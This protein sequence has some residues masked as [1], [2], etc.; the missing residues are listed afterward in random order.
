MPSLEER[1]ALPGSWEEAGW[2]GQAEDCWLTSFLDPLP[3]PEP[4]REQA[5]V[6]W[7]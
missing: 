1:L 7:E 5:G 2:G 6:F 4:L 3:P